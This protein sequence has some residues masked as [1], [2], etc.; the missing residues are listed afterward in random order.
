M[1]LMIRIVVTIFILL[2]SNASI[3]TNPVVLYDGGQ[4]IPAYQYKQIIQG[5]EIPDFGHLWAEEQ[6]LN[7]KQKT[8]PSDP[9]N[10]L[11]LITSKLTP[12]N[13]A[14][15]KVTFNKLA[16]PVCIIGSDKRSLDWLNKYHETLLNNGVLCWL[17]HANN[18]ADVR[19]VV[20]AL[21]GIP[22]TIANGDAIAEHFSITHYPAL[23]TH[24]YIEQ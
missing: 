15:R 13:V 12:G 7:A 6:K 18:V 10:W 16:S 4:S 17:V 24:R 9:E 1:I 21:N 3:A 23:I 19:N 20:S 5:F 2:I 14:V 22:M 11:P 8:N